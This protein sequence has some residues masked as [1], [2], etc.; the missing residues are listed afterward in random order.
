M[1]LVCEAL[2]WY[3]Y[4][5]WPCCYTMDTKSSL[6]K[7]WHWLG[8]KVSA[9]LSRP[10]MF[11]GIL[12]LPSKSF[13]S[14]VL[15]EFA[16]FHCK[17]LF[18]FYIGVIYIPMLDYFECSNSHQSVHHTSESKT[19][20]FWKIL[21]WYLCI[22]YACTKGSRSQP[23]KNKSMLV[24]HE[25]VRGKLRICLYCLLLRCSYQIGLTTD[26]IPHLREKSLLLYVFMH[27]FLQRFFSH[28]FFSYIDK[29][30]QWKKEDMYVRITNHKRTC[31]LGITMIRREQ[32]LDISL[33]FFLSIK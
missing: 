29:T 32:R 30:N 8:L 10:W 27:L 33:L 13:I 18:V 3:L 23:E 9:R 31:M 14:I 5:G 4:H 21:L 7:T 6:L 15:L 2:V 26:L 19:W 24:S 11:F 17:L 12:K 25:G 28:L 1:G 16:S 22:L 20:V